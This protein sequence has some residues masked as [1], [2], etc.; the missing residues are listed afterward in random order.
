MRGEIPGELCEAKRPP[1]RRRTMRRLN[2]FRAP[3]P[4]TR[5]RFPPRLV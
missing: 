4:S 1:S 3:F 2:D 5:F